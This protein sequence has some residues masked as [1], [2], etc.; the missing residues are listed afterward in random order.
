M[1]VQFLDQDSTWKPDPV[2]KCQMQ[3]HVN[4]T[5]LMQQCNAP[6]YLPK[7]DEFQA[8]AEATTARALS[9]SNPAEA[10]GKSLTEADIPK[11]TT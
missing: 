10:L 1:T 3:I 8:R 4:A 2:R 6:Q 9:A 5:M 11:I 7:A